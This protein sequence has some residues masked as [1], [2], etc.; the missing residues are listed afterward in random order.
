MW[1]NDAEKS[2]G[3]K[4]LEIPGRGTNVEQNS[5]N[6]KP[7]EDKKQIDARPSEA[8]P[9]TV[10]KAYHP[11]ARNGEVMRHPHQQNRNPAQS[12]EFWHASLRDAVRHVGP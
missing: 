3:I 7:G 9:V 8:K 5:T 10:K 12:V 1:R 6:E 4:C 11:L 2:A